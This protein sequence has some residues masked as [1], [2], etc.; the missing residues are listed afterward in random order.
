[1]SSGSQRKKRGRDV[2]LP[3]L[4][5]DSLGYTLRRAHVRAYDMLGEMYGPEILSPTRLTALSIIGALQDCSQSALGAELG[6][7]RASTVKLVD[8]FEKLGLVA[9]RQIAGDRRTNRLVL[10]EAGRC[11]LFEW[12]ERMRLY[13]ERISMRLTSGERAKLIELLGKVAT[14]EVDEGAT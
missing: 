10:T 9:R 12:N 4:R 2:K 11:E 6:I 14:L 8:S 1:M 3:D 7:N 13:E 5:D